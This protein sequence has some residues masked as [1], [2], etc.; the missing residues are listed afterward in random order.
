[1]DLNRSHYT[2]DDL[3]NSR[4]LHVGVDRAATAAMCT[5]H[6]VTI[7]AI[8]ELV[9]GG[10]RVVL[11]NAQDAQVIRKAFGKRVLSGPVTRTKWLR[12]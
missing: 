8:E 1:M 7:S 10:T 4:A 12:N 2:T 3:P 5:K 11:M 9:S 6:G